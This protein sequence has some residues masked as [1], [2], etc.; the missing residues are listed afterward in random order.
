PRTIL[1]FSGKCSKNKIR[2]DL[3]NCQVAALET[4]QGDD[5]VLYRNEIHVGM[6]SIVIVLPFDLEGT[7]KLKEFK[8]FEIR[9]YDTK[10]RVICLNVKTD[11]RFKGQYWLSHNF[12]GKLKVKHIVDVIAHCQRLDRLKAFL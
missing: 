3:K 12:F 2:Q 4:S 11:S 1:D 5:V 6:Y 9:I 10:A 8:D 7:H